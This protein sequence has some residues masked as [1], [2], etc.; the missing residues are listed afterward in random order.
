M[1]HNPMDLH[2]MLQA[3]LYLYARRVAVTEMR[4]HIWWE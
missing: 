4:L 3:E 1:S 2:G